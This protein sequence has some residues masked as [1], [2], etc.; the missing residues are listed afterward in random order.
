MDVSVADPY[1]LN[2]FISAQEPVIDQVY[3]ELEKGEKQ[4]HWMWFVFPQILGLGQSEMAKLYS[5]ASR[6]EATAYLAHPVLG[7]RLEKCSRIVG[8]NVERSAQ[9]MFGRTDALKLRSS[10][11]L[12]ASVAEGASIFHEVLNKYY[13]GKPDQ[14]T[15]AI[16]EEA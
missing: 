10:M 9:Q 2:R 5:I 1:K 7:K 13:G 4:T 6:D 11:T 14:A 16:L 3:R 12:F 15:L 8:N